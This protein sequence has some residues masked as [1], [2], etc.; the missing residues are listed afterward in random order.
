MIPSLPS[1]TWSCTTLQSGM[2]LQRA[3]P[4][5][6]ASLGEKNPEDTLAEL[7][8]LEVLP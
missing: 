7:Q 4:L 1:R 5:D 8:A 2:A 3:V 6:L